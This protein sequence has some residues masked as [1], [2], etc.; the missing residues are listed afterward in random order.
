MTELFFRAKELVYN[1]WSYKCIGLFENIVSVYNWLYLPTGELV[2][3]LGMSMLQFL[4]GN[5]F[6]TYYLVSHDINF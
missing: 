1:S 4:K 6:L 3:D 2:F 5:G